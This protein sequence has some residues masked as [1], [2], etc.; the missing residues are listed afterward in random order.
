MYFDEPVVIRHASKLF[1]SST[2][3]KTPNHPLYPI[4]SEADSIR[5]TQYLNSNTEVRII[6]KDYCL[7]KHTP[8]KSG[9]TCK[10][11]FFSYL[12]TMNSNRLVRH[13][14]L[15]GNDSIVDFAKIPNSIE[16]VD[17]KFYM[18]FEDG[19]GMILTI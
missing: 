6:L 9:E 11:T 14:M 16:A 5:R 18:L 19:P 10:T 15:I 3:A 2:A 8:F 13:G 7:D 17:L 12:S 4:A 1:L